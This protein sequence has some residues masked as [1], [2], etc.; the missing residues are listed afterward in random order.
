MVIHYQKPSNMAE[1]KQLCKNEWARIPLYQ[2]KRLTSYKKHFVIV[3]SAKNGTTSYYRW[4]HF[5]VTDIGVAFFFL[6]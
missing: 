1:L 2:C 4:S 6:Q 5:H 3:V